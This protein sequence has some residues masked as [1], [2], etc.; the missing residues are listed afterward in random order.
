M[1]L[2]SL[3][4][5]LFK[6]RSRELRAPLEDYL[7]ECLADLFNRMD[8]DA[9]KWLVR[10]LFIPH[11]AISAWDSADPS[12][13]LSMETQYPTNV[14]RIDIVLSLNEDPFLVIENKV[15]APIGLDADQ[16][17]QLRRYGSW[18]SA[19]KG[20]LPRI[21]CLLSHTTPPTNEFM[22]GGAASGGARPHFVRWSAVGACLFDIARGA[23]PS[24][25]EIQMLARELHVFLT[26]KNMS[27]EFANRE[28]FAAALLYLRSGEKMD[29][30]FKTI[31]NH[32][33]TLGG[34]FTSKKTLY[35]QYLHFATKNRLVWGWKT[36]AHPTLYGLF[37]AY[38]IAYEPMSTFRD[39]PAPREDSAFILVGAE[40]KKSIHAM[41]IASDAHEKPW[42]AAEADGWTAVVS[43]KPLHTLMKDPE[44]FASNMIEWI[45]GEVENINEF[46]LTLKSPA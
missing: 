29:H 17:D 38:G 1:P 24:G 46:V 25:A 23:V 30:T 27:H 12:A 31:F 34:Q 39:S 32:V 11:G 35:E 8:L 37:F 42:M 36:L 10:R 21:V 13:S 7:S 14:G 41:R 19:T 43:F 45:N 16:N 6:Y 2:K 5:S 20:S 3:Y 33:S 18:V 40:D 22:K 28:D 4:G 9:Q 26:E 44:A 15:S